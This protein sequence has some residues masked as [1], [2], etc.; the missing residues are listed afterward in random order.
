MT[1]SEQ[2]VHRLLPHERTGVEVEVAEVGQLG[3]HGLDG[4][5]SDATTHS[6]TKESPY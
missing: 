6:E 3:G 5:A 1:L 4:L 2:C